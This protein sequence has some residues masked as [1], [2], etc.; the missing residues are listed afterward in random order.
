DQRCVPDHLAFL[1]GRVVERLVVGGTRKRGQRGE[2]EQAGAQHPDRATLVAHG[3]FLLGRHPVRHHC[4]YQLGLR[5][6]L[7]LAMPSRASSEFAG[8]CGFLRAKMSATGGEAKRSI[9]AFNS[10]TA[11]C[12]PCSSASAIAASVSSSFSALQTSCARP[13]RNASAAAMRS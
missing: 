9:S 13:I 12:A 6:S 5:F 11:P 8:S 2:R 7:K 10:R 4:R 1:L 3:A